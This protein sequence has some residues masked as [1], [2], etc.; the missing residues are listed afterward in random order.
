M[1][2]LIVI[3]S[4]LFVEKKNPPFLILNFQNLFLSDP[5]IQDMKFRYEQMFMGLWDYLLPYLRAAV[6]LVVVV[7]LTKS[8]IQTLLL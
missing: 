8:V 7:F 6:Y 3:T 5:K 1:K 4:E 2:K